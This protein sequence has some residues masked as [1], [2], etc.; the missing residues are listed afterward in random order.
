VADVRRGRDRGSLRAGRDVPY[1][2][3][4]DEPIRGRDAIVAAWLGDR[5]EPGSWEASYAPS[6]IEGDRAIATG[7]TRYQNGRVFS[8]LFALTFDADGHC[9]R[10]VEWFM[11]HR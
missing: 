11:E 6:L 5:D 7:E 8:N 3:Y 1:H 2:P 10:F 9:T 4:D